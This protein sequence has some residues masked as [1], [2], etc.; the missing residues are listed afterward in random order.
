MI[1]IY[2]D[3]HEQVQKD[4]EHSCYPYV[5]IFAQQ[6]SLE[7]AM[8][9]LLYQRDIRDVG[10]LGGFQIEAVDIRQNKAASEN[11]LDMQVLDGEGGLSLAFDYTASHY[12]AESMA[13]FQSLFKQVAEALTQNAGQAGITI[14]Q[15][16]KELGYGKKGGF[17]ARLFGGRK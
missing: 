3:V 2:A 7:T 6:G 9:T 10:D 1:N 11:I 13:K 16:K 14:G 12:K 17:L 5:E 15:L 8:A 4:I